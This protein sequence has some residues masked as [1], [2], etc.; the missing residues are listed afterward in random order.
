[1]HPEPVVVD[2]TGAD[3]ESSA[4]ADVKVGE[5]EI[6]D[7][8]LNGVTFELPAE[9]TSLAQSGKVDFL[10]FHDFRVNGVSVV[11]EEYKH[12][13]SFRKNETITLPEP[14]TICLPTSG[15]LKGAWTEMRE[16]RKE[17]LVT[18][19]VF[20]FGRFRKFGMYHK[21]VIP[22]DVILKIKNP[23]LADPS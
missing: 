8:S 7:V 5:P 4:K 23:L 6:I 12:P 19:R 14:A 10:T 20:V 22:V 21:R 1:M 9:V 3:A 16:S 18:G 11:I 15:L 2:R 13:F 17:W